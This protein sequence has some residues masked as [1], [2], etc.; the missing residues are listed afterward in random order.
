MN[1]I[2]KK[3]IEALQSDKIRE[4][5]DEINSLLLCNHRNATAWLYLARSF[6][7]MGEI[8]KTRNA[9]VNFLRYSEDCS[10]QINEIMDFR[11][12]YK[13][14]IDVSRKINLPIIEKEPN[15]ENASH[16]DVVN[17]KNDMIE[18]SP[19][20]TNDNLIN[21][22]NENNGKNLATDVDNSKAYISQVD[23][24][25][26]GTVKF[27]NDLRGYGFIL[28]E[29]GTEIFVHFKNI[30]K[31]SQRSLNAGE[32]VTF[33]ISKTPKGLAATNV[34]SIDSSV[35]Q[36]ENTKPAMF[37][38][39]SKLLSKFKYIPNMEPA[40]AKT[41]LE[42]EYK[43]YP[44]DIKL[45]VNYISILQRLRETQVALKVIAESLP[46]FSSSPDKE[47]LLLPKAQI[48]TSLERIDDAEQTYTELIRYTGKNK[49]GQA[50]AHYLDQLARL[51]LKNGK[52]E[53]ALTSAQ[54]AI[55][56]VPE[57]L[58]TRNLIIQIE[59]YIKLREAGEEFSI[60]VGDE[61]IDAISPMLKIDIE[62]Y[63]YKDEGIIKHGSSPTIDDIKRIEDNLQGERAELP[64]R[65]PLYLELTKA[66]MDLPLGTYDTT[67]LQRALAH[68]AV[69]RGTNIYNKFISTIKEKS[70]D[71]DKVQ[72]MKDSAS[73]YFI[74]AL[75]LQAGKESQFLETLSNYLKIQI[76][77]EMVF[78]KYTLVTLLDIKSFAQIFNFCRNHT[79]SNI[80]KTLLKGI[81][82][83]G[84]ANISIWNNFSSA[85][86]GYDFFGLLSAEKTKKQMYMLINEI[87]N[88]EFDIAL[89]PGF[90]FKSV[91]DRRRKIAKELFSESYKFQKVTF[92][93]ETIKEVIEKWQMF[94]GYDML[95][96]DTDRALY[97]KILD[98]LKLFEPYLTRTSEERTNIL[99]KTRTSLE[100]NIKFIEENTTYW[101][102]TI[103]YPNL[104]KWRKK[105]DEIEKNRLKQTL[106]ILKVILDPPFLNINENLC[107]VSLLVKNSGIA[108][109][110]GAIIQYKLSRVDN[111][112]LL[113]S[114]EQTIVSEISAKGEVIQI[115]KFPEKDLLNID[116]ATILIS[117][118]PI[119]EGKKLASSDYSF[120]LE[121][122]SL[123]T[124]TDQDILWDETKIPSK[125]LFKGRDRI[126][127]I[128]SKHLSSSNRN[129]TYIL[130]GLTRTGKSSILRYLSEMI[131]LK[132][133][134]DNKHH[135][136][137]SFMWDLS[138]AAAETKASD[139]W[140][141]LIFES[142]Y[143]KIQE[144][145][146][147]GT[148]SSEALPPFKGGDMRFK[149]WDRL[150]HHLNEHNLY[151]VFL[152]DEFSYY[153]QLVDQKRIDSAFLASIRSFAIEG[154]ASFVF[155]GTYDLKDLIKDPVY[156][157][158][159]QLVNTLEMPISQI[160]RTA[161][162][163]LINV[164][165]DRLQF[166]EAAIEKI[167]ILSNQIPYFIQIVCKNCG[168]YAIETRKRVIGAPEV[169]H[170][171]QTLTG[172][173]RKAPNSLIGLL[174][175][176]V[177]MN[178]QYSTQ[179]AK[180]I[181]ALISTIAY[182]NRGF[183]TPRGIRHEEILQ[184][185]GQKKVTAFSPKLAD[186]LQNLISKGIL[187]QEEDE[188]SFIYK[189]GVDLFRRWWAVQ[190]SN[191]ELQFASL[192]D[193]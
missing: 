113:K 159:G 146:K 45:L 143:N 27:F 11:G 63:D 193:E 124:L 30:M 51:Q 64:E 109:A 50:H 112:D 117:I 152:V 94:S 126:L 4:F 2:G 150:I 47:K 23:R 178:N 191:I 75:N 132:Q 168:Y 91:F 73:S 101:G 57:A 81:I 111:G 139:M 145:T 106:P 74:E 40:Y 76:L 6:D 13:V 123:S 86:E 149:D 148:I 56:L 121:K 25:F 92:S 43:N 89:K 39:D 37:P 151:P 95:L 120:T 142:C 131:D 127:T 103:Y 96:S 85:K 21:T 192:R 108:T 118:A 98:M 22:Q 188:D 144:Q 35:L 17:G 104:K 60:D 122:E 175:Q 164:M 100:E 44:Y 7:A 129:K 66:Y 160:D 83:C 180:E 140:A 38:A 53:E 67:S 141:K 1:I 110:E 36:L 169:E 26:V 24:T 93:P 46:R 125:D 28:L 185:W 52:L 170:V 16:K 99:Y 72:I 157:I 9:Y 19:S 48:L 173:E 29:D 15:G 78:K 10:G 5:I 156:G 54:Q 90:F 171:I 177:F 134:T 190:H 34:K 71:Q 133:M 70:F 189:I 20:S 163:D 155:A 138:K 33:E 84:A 158:T 153:K 55:K 174:S 154:L 130:W 79:D 14:D 116:V 184:Y 82:A 181:G 32:K 137:I 179:D 69:L 182:F 172:Q 166:T 128:L 136:F 8:D 183:I 59:R 119:Y 165:Q 115:L 61:Q 187:I 58:L 42:R 41:Q 80:Y 186:S 167:L 62:E 97:R 18:V 135:R 147:K 31:D 102:R 107:K 87:E 161:A 3:F 88:Y 114:G 12:K 176:G 77:Y 162:I 105:I 49:S 68:Y 65:Y